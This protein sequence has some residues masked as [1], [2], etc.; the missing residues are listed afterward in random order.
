MLCQLGSAQALRV[1]R[2]QIKLID[3]QE[4]SAAAKGA[5]EAGE[6]ERDQC[7]QRLDMLLAQQPFCPVRYRISCET[8]SM[9]ESDLDRLNRDHADRQQ[10]EDQQRV[11]WHQSC[12]QAER[13][14]AEARI[15][16]GKLARARDD[17]ASLA[18]ISIQS[19]GKG[20]SPWN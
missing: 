2:E 9:A 13:I 10:A 19:A 4:S 8:L 5:M 3:A 18:A 20:K 17:K 15:L 6:H 11:L 12:R 1:A 14:G 16:A 7:Q